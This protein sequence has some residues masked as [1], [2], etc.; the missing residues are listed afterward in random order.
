MR[1]I[2]TFKKGCAKSTLKGLSEAD[3]T[4]STFKKGSS[5]ADCAKSQRNFIGKRFK[6]SRL[7]QITTFKK[8]SSEADCIKS[9]R[10]LLGKHI[11]K[12]T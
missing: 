2:T 8:G 11:K 6:R 5:E 4:K 1:Q 3:Y 9:Q 10:K 7:R 12:T